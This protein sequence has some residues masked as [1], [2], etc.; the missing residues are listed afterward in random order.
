MNI[1]G[2]IFMVSV[3]FNAAARSVHTYIILR[4]LSKCYIVDIF[5]RKKGDDFY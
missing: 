1:A 3:G 2:W 5:G 4:F